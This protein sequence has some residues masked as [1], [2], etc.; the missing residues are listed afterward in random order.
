M[1]NLIKLAAN[2]VVKN[3]AFLSFILCFFSLLTIFNGYHLNAKDNLGNHIA[4]KNLDMNLKNTNKVKYIDV[5]LGTGNGMGFS[6]S[7]L[8]SISMGNN[9]S[10]WYGPVSSYSIKSTMTNN[11]VRG[12]TCGVYNKTPIVAL[13]TEG[14]FQL[15]GSTTTP[16]G[17]RLYVQDGISTEKILT[18]RLDTIPTDTNTISTDE[19]RLYVENGISTERLEII[20]TD[21]TTSEEYR[22][23][24]QD[25]ISTEKVLT[26][27]LEIASTDTSS[28]DGFR[29]YVQDGIST[30]KIKIA[31]NDTSM[32]IPD[33]FRLCV[34]DGISTE[35][36][37][38][39]FNDTS[40]TTPDGF[41]LY[42]EEGILTEK[43]KI[44]SNDTSMTTPDGFKLYVEE[45]ILTERVK[46]ASVGTDNWADFVFDKDYQLNSIYEVEKFIT[47]NKHLP[48]VPSA[49][50]V[51]NDGVDLIEMDA[52]LLRQIEEL[53]LHMIE[54]K[55]ENEELRKIIEQQK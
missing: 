55:K 15:N 14:I 22:L 48:N 12:W 51:K 13:N 1:E 19:F 10:Y 26:E 49:N 38:I 20:S 24:V 18:E 45:G 21:T 29:L 9:S 47:K 23:Y 52:T 8:Y 36:I 35:K 4:T 11:V 53:W 37:K 30:E 44:A 39:G 7:N 32:T 46:I 2:M 28:I 33:G 16:D 50:D 42:V 43:V 25:G 6:S 34:Q 27:S 17:F 40:M 54:L 3:N 41:K 5:R 31:S